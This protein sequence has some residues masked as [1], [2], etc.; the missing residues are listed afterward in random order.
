MIALLAALALLQDEEDIA[1]ASRA[2]LD[3]GSFTIQIAPSA[4]MK[5]ALP[6]DRLQVAGVT[7]VA[8]QLA[9]GTFRS[10]DGTWE[11]IGRS[12]TGVLRAKSGWARADDVAAALQDEIER[13]NGDNDRDRGNVSA[14][15]ENYRRLIALRQMVARSLP[16]TA[17]L[18]GLQTEFKRAKKGATESVDGKPCTVY[19]GALKDLSAQALLVGPYGEYVKS[20]AL[21]VIEFAGSARVWVNADGLVAKTEH[22]A[23]GK[24]SIR[25]DRSNRVVPVGVTVTCKFVKIGTTT[26]EVPKEAEDKIAEMIAERSEK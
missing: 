2:T 25:D 24:Y 22:K 9:D 4:D 23:T 10:T 11:L 3:K 8:E 12:G 17:I 16:P 26:Y 5:D 19:E 20:G 6:K 1:K 21:K 15:K 13:A 7:I 14:A 18:T